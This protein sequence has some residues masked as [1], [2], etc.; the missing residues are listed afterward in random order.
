M[1]TRRGVRAT[2]LTAAVLVVLGASG[3]VVHRAGVFTRWFARDTENAAEIEQLRHAPP[4]APRAAVGGGWPQFLGPN[5]DGHAPAGPFRTDWEKRPPEKLWS[6]PVGGGYSSFAVVGGKLY[7]QDRQG[8]SERVVCLDAATGASVWE[9]T[10]P[11]SYDGI[12]FDA[13]P[14]AT[15]TVDGDRV[16]TVGA[17][18]LMH[19]LEAAPGQAPRVVWKHDLPGEFN[20]RTPQWGYAC[21]PLLDGDTVVVQPGGRKG[22]VAAFDRA[23]GLIRW[24]AGTNPAGYSSPSVATVQGVRAV[25]ALTGDTLLCLRS[26]GTLMGSYP[27]PTQH[28]GNIATP[29]VLDDYVF[30]S[31]AYG[32]GCALLRL[33]PD[34]DRLRLEPVYSK[35]NKP[36]RTHH[37]T[38]VA[39]GRHLY[40]FDGTNDEARLVCFSLID[41]A[42]VEGWE[43]PR[44]RNGKIVAV[45]G[46]LVILTQTGDLILVQAT[47]DEYRPVATVPLGFSGHQ[48]WALPVV[49]DGRLYVRGPD[50]IEC[51]NVAP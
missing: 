8:S 41:G 13:G 33:K 15:P 39:V 29:L 18:G 1:T 16:Y 9:H 43:A 24:T 45:G 37:G 32:T 2:A 47:P 19:C 48:N 6:A 36:L 50:R 14:R 21:S 11:A 42:T 20:G 49:A 10:Y 34:A 17:S 30:I 40:A 35:R 27:W 4:A 5:R 3:Y 51:F 46:Y 28:Q 23:T 22:S 38:A 26:D 44:V 7:T 31:A 12:G 25:F